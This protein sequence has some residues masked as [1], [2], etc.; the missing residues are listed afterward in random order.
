MYFI[1][2]MDRLFYGAPWKPNFTTHPSSDQAA[3]ECII[4]EPRCHDNLS[5]VLRNA[6]CM[7]P[8]AAM[9]IYHS[10]K[11]EKFVQD[12]L[13]ENHT[14]NLKCFTEDNIT[15]REYCDI[16]CTPDFWNIAS[17]RCLIFQTDSGIR[18]NN[19]LR[20]LEYDYVGAPWAWPIRG[21]CHINIGNGGFSLRSPHVM[22]EI[23]THFVRDPSYPDK[24]LG[25][26]EDIFF[27]R[28][29]VNMNHVSLPTFDEASA[30]AVEYNTH[31]DPFGFHQA[32]GIHHPPEIV[33][34]W[35]SVTD[36]P[37]AE[38]ELM[39]IADAWV[40]SEGGRQVSTPKLNQW[41]ALGIGSA[42][43][44]LPAHTLLTAMPFDI[45]PGHRKWLNV[46][47]SNKKECRV[48]LYRNR[49]MTDIKVAP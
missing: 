6:S 37:V 10:K 7:L 8:N 23:C 22:K 4:I 32:Y 36:P 25:E 38:S 21:D 27:A 41:L 45:H 26:P 28:T 12:I 48:P 18:K 31:P 47:F 46:R 16:L 42:G 13:G 20:F 3:L 9:T 5:A 17:P 24:E 1:A 33:R 29:L 19:I 40:E 39:R 49:C 35:M 11:N 30:F 43:F 15:R 2:P 44:C 14:V 34:Q